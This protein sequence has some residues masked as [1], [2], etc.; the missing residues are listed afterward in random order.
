MLQGVL[1]PAVR[2]RAGAQGGFACSFIFLTFI[3]G[4]FLLLGK[5]SFVGT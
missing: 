5:F 2:V 4:C 3:S 1:L